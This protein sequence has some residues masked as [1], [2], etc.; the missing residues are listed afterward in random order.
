MDGVGLLRLCSE[1]LPDDST[2]VPKHEGVSYL[3]LSVFY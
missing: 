3:L 1:K 2:P